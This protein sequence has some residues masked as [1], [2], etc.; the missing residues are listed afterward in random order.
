M[1]TSVSMYIKGQ[2]KMLLGLIL[3]GCGVAIDDS[4]TGYVVIG[5]GILVLISGGR[6]HLK[7]QD[8]K[9]YEAGISEDQLKSIKSEAW[10]KARKESRDKEAL[11]KEIARQLRK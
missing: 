6:T 11:A 1:K 9:A 10:A 4:T 3:V 7:S 5:I 2:L 8:Q